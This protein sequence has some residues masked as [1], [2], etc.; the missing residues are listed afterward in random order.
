MTNRVLYLLGC[1]APPVLLLDRPVRAARAAGWTVC[2]GLTP[3]A[4]EWLGDD[5]VAA[6]EET[7]GR[8]VRRVK[9]RP[10][11]VSP[12][13]EPSVSVVA[14]ATLHTVD[15]VALG[16]TPDWL[17]GHAVEAIGRR[18]PLVV[19]PCVNSAYA[20]H[21]QFGRSIATLREAGVR[22]LYGAGSYEPH[23][24]GGGPA[25][26]YPWHL[27]LAAAEEAVRPG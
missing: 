6:L 13:P 24:P 7:T 26:E 25:E 1:A 10:G 3:T 16:L 27:A 23:A 5:G 18:L 9:R 19:M 17:S 11:E 8:P 20:T 22:V 14:P 4:A 12:W 21:P 2:V 15:K